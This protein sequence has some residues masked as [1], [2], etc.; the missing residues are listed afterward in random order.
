MIHVSMRA[1]AGLCSMGKSGLDSPSAGSF[2]GFVRLSIL[3]ADVAKEQ[4]LAASIALR[5]KSVRESD[6]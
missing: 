3:Q 6:S 4:A 1:G 2:I 5:H